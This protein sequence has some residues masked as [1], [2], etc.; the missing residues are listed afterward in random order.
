MT[1]LVQQRWRRAPRI[2]ESTRISHGH[3]GFRCGHGPKKLGAH[4]PP[5]RATK[6]SQTFPRAK[7]DCRR[8]NRPRVLG[9]DSPE[10]PRDSHN[11]GLPRYNAGRH[12][13]RSS[14]DR[15]RWPRTRPPRYS[16]PFNTLLTRHLN[17]QSIQPT[18]RL[19][20]LAP[21]RCG[22]T[23]M[24]G[25]L[26]GKRGSHIRWRATDAVGE[27][28]KKALI[29][30]FRGGIVAIQTNVQYQERAAWPLSIGSSD[31]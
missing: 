30:S 9:P 7:A 23:F 24:A 27:P 2:R 17:A 10:Q 19:L 22:G 6:P 8:Q 29:F 16:A 4:V 15:H 5:R 1:L 11:V 25:L 13:H 3:P 28:S 26:G 21:M 14:K 31:I 18:P 20:G 12:P